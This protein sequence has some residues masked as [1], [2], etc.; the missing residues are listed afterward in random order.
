[1]VSH[2]SNRYHVSFEQF[3]HDPLTDFADSAGDENL[4]DR[5]RSHYFEE[6]TA[7]ARRRRE[8]VL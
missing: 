6:Y 4:H 5:I 1:M 2:R 3:V 8:K 7:A